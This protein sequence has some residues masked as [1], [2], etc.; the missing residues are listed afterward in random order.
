MHASRG[1]DD[2]GCRDSAGGRGLVQRADER[3]NAVRQ[4]D[5]SAGGRVDGVRRASGDAHA[6][7]LDGDASGSVAPSDGAIRPQP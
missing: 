6:S 2:D 1:R 5:R 3:G 7:L 4:V